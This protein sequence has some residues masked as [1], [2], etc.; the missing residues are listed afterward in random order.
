MIDSI[1]EM[2]IIDFV[3]KNKLTVKVDKQVRDL[4]LHRFCNDFIK[5]KSCFSKNNLILINQ[6]S[7]YVH[8][9]VTIEIFIDLDEV[10]F[11]HLSQYIM[12]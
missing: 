3:E 8:A 10:S 6:I 12:Q 2:K 7:A 9:L 1:K 11:N 4:T 5:T